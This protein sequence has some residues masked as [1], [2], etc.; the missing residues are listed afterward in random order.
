[1]LVFYLST[2]AVVPG[3]SFSILIKRVTEVD[4]SRSLTQK[5]VPRRRFLLG[6]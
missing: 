1:M 6:P 3:I 2:S 4:S 5:Q